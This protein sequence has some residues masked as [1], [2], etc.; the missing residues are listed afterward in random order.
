MTTI[1]DPILFLPFCFLHCGE[2]GVEF[3]VEFGGLL[4]QQR[5]KLLR[6]DLLLDTIIKHLKNW[7]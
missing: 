4:H 1:Y 7:K 5:L 6:C 3:G 2:L